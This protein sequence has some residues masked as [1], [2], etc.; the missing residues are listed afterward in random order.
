MVI[1]LSFSL[2]FWIDFP[3]AQHN[4]C[5]VTEEQI[6]SF[7][8]KWNEST[9]CNSCVEQNELCLFFYDLLILQIVAAYCNSMFRSL[10]SY[11]PSYNICINSSLNF[12]INWSL[13]S[14]FH[15]HIFSLLTNGHEGE[16]TWR[17]LEQEYDYRQEIKTEI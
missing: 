12:V 14:F 10:S 1:L 17:T 3:S 15:E 5:W 8:K 7:G 2:V 9:S 4:I 13:P 11:Y 16:I 6:F